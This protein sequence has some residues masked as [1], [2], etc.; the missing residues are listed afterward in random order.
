MNEG[1]TFGERQGWHLPGFDVS[2]WG[3]RELNDGLPDAT[4]GV[5]VFVTTFRLD[6]P[7]GVDVHMSFEFDNN[8]G[9]TGVPYRAYLYVNGWM[10]GKRVANLG[11]V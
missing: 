9:D 4:A 1:G 2:K 7:R 8:V 6:N 5:G 10:M 3:A 11:C